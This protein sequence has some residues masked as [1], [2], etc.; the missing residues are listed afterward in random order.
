MHYAIGDVHG[1]YHDLM[2]L[3]KTIEEKDPDAQ[4]ILLGDIIDRGPDTLKVLEWA[5]NHVKAGGKYQCLRGNHEDLAMQWYHDRFLAWERKNKHLSPSMQEP[6]PK[7]KFD[8]SNIVES[9]GLTKSEYLK[10]IIEFMDSLPY[11]LELNISVD[12]PDADKRGLSKQPLEGPVSYKLVHGWY[13]D[14]VPTEMIQKHM[15]LR[16]RIFSGNPNAP[17]IIVHGHTPTTNQEYINADEA[18]TKPGQ[19]SY[20]INAINIDGGRAEE[21]WRSDPCMLCGICLETLEEFY[22]HE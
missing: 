7:S 14:K 18:H 2:T 5:M 10:P 4:F 11:N 21:N 13:K 16:G 8:F 12:C 15:N 6:L 22:A 19:I 3:I 9:E 1:Y 20:R 17:Y